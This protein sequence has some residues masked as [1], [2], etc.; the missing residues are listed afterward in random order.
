MKNVIVYL[1]ERFCYMLLIILVCHLCCDACLIITHEFR[2]T[3]FHRKI[4]TQ[5]LQ[6]DSHLSS[7]TPPALPSEVHYAEPGTS[8]WHCCMR[9]ITIELHPSVLAAHCL[10]TY[11]LACGKVRV[12]SHGAWQSKLH[13]AILVH[14]PEV[15]T[16][17]LAKANNPTGALVVPVNMH[18]RRIIFIQ[19]YRGVCEI[20]MCIREEIRQE[21]RQV[22]QEHRGPGQTKPRTI[23]QHET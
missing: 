17:V 18:L 9:N 22:W 23:I 7:Y 13:R 19:L 10:A 1:L 2:P 12:T 15:T 5:I 16:I 4:K 11:G 21:L 20:W 8:K 6:R 3:T 14:Y